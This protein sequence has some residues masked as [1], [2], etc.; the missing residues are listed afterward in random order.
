M[1]LFCRLY[2]EYLIRHL[3]LR[4]GDAELRGFRHEWIPAEYTVENHGR[5][6]AFMLAV[7]D[8]PGTLPVFRNNKF[9]S[10]LYG[11]RSHTIHWQGFGTSRG[12]F[13]LG[14]C[15]IR[16]ADPLGLFPFSLTAPDTTMLYVYPAPGYIGLKAPDS[17]PLG[18]IASTNPFNEDLTRRR[19][20][21][22]TQPETN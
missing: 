11:R 6:P 13:I 14:P 10:N 17:I 22:N 15:V 12:L 20:V 16:G 21:R 4:R 7:T 3:N 18:V 2:S 1:I 19:S 5:I 9:L 8:M